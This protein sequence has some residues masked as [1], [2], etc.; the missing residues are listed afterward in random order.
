MYTLDDDNVRY[1]LPIHTIYFHPLSIPTT[2]A[3]RQH[4]HYIVPN[5]SASPPVCILL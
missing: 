1:F 3:I 2:I 4:P 5:L